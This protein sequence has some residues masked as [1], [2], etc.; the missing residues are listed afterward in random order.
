VLK[1]SKNGYKDKTVRIQ[2]P[3]GY[4]LTIAV[5]LST[6]TETAKTQTASPPSASQTGIPSTTAA[7]TPGG[8]KLLILDTPT[9][10]LRVRADASAGA[11]E[12][13]RVNPGEVYQMVDSQTGWFEIKLSDGTL[14]WISS[15]YARKQ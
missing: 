9:G 6:S 14:G 15:Q 13:G 2:T 3:K 11:A 5:Y 12:L 4:K 7:P 1:V 10:F 8:T